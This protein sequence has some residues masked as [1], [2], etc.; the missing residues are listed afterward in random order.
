M[1]EQVPAIGTEG[2]PY[3]F[4]SEEISQEAQFLGDC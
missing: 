3:G 4:S 1:E 2:F